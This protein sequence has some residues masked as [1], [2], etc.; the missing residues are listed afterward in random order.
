MRWISPAKYVKY[1]FVFARYINYKKDVKMT[2][3]NVIIAR[4]THQ[5]DYERR[6]DDRRLIK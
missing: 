1:D 6:R 2:A 3:I 5:L 4:L